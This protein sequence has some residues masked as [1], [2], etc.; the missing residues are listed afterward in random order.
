MYKTERFFDGRLQAFKPA[1]I[2]V[3]K[4]RNIMEFIQRNKYHAEQKYLHNERTVFYFFSFLFFSSL[5]GDH[6]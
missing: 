4:R 2:F 1:R 3:P 5:F 6:K